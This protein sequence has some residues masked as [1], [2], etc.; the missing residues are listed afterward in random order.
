MNINILFA[1]AFARS[2]GRAKLDTERRVIEWQHQTDLRGYTL[3]IIR[4]LANERWLWHIEP[5]GFAWLHIGAFTSLS[6]LD[7]ALCK[8]DGLIKDLPILEPEWERS[9]ANL[10]RRGG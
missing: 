7:E 10:A 3:R 2:A 6:G 9:R 8:M 1:I 4:C 5:D